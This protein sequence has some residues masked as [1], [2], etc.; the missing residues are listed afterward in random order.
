MRVAQASSFCSVRCPVSVRIYKCK[1][2][3][4][5]QGH[6]T[7]VAVNS[8]TNGDAPPTDPVFGSFIV[9]PLILEQCP[10]NFLV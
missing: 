3:Q 7:V 9:V 4:P 8:C 2:R 6:V 10:D 5:E 1:F